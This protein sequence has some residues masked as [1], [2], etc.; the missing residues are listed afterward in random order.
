MET[1]HQ[2][3]LGGGRG[4]I[5]PRARLAQHDEM[6]FG[7]ATN[8]TWFLVD[9]VARNLGVFEDK[10]LPVLDVRMSPRH[11]SLT[12]GFLRSL[13][14]NLERTIMSRWNSCQITICPRFVNMTLRWTGGVHYRSTD[15]SLFLLRIIS[16]CYI[17]LS[18]T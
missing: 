15:Q 17:K 3:V 14:L 1:P 12:S 11:V 16:C 13:S 2:D 18:I 10:L 7:L 4:Y 8:M 9:G 5:A 6:L